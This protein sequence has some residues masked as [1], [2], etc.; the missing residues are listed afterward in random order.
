MAKAKFDWVSISRYRA[1][2]HTLRECS[3]EFGFTPAAWYKAMERGVVRQ[4]PKQ[5]HGGRQKYDWQSIQRYYDEV[6]TY[7][8]CKAHFGFA[9][10]SW[11][12]AVRRGAINARARV[13]RIEKLL[14]EGRCTTNIKSGAASS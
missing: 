12:N 1:A 7:R 11:R 13:W 4:L 2:G 5:N 14:R 6:H 10:E 9:A 8:Q 3:R